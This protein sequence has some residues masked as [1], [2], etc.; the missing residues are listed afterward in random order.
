MNV[1]LVMHWAV[2]GNDL[3]ISYGGEK[4]GLLQ[5][6]AR[7]LLSFVMFSFLEAYMKI[8]ASLLTTV[9]T[10]VGMY[11]FWII[12]R[13]FLG[14]PITAYV[15]RDALSG[16]CITLLLLAFVGKK[17]VGLYLTLWG[18]P[19]LLYGFVG[20]TY[21]MPDKNALVALF[22]TDFHETSEYLKLI[23]PTVY[24][25]YGAV[26]I[27]IGA[28]FLSMRRADWSFL[29]KRRVW[30]ALLVLLFL[31]SGA[32]MLKSYKRH[33]SIQITDWRIS[34]VVLFKDLKAAFNSITEEDKKR[35]LFDRSTHWRVRPIS[36]SSKGCDVCILV[37][38]ESARRDFMQAY[39]APWKDT[40]WMSQTPGLKFDN[41][42]SASSAT[43]PSLSVELYAPDTKGMA[44]WGDNI[45]SLA[46]LAGYRTEWISNQNKGGAVD[47]PVSQAAS[48]ADKVV[49][50]T[51]SV[52]V[53]KLPD[54]AML[55][56]IA[57]ALDNK[58]KVF[59][60]VHLM[61]SHPMA[62]NRT[63]GEYDD[64]FLSKELSCYIKSLKNT[65]EF[66]RKV[67]KLAQDSANGRSW[68]LMYTSDHALDFTKTSEGWAMK[69]MAERQNSF[70]V[71]LFI[72]GSGYQEK[73]EI[74]ALRSGRY[75]SLL[76]A[77]W[78]GLKAEGKEPA[79]ECDWLSN[80][81]CPDQ[82]KVRAWY[83]PFF[84][85]E[86]LPDYPLSDFLVDEGVQ[87]NQ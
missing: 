58:G 51:E 53:T 67:A 84:P 31:I 26:I 32:S 82:N 54:D 28:L 19:S 86:S 43:A 81:A 72:T 1:G 2:L 17:W 41:F 18:I 65:D 25:A 70:Q 71:P 40:P 75:F 29:K 9:V 10:V 42:V 24:M 76:V 33:G 21:G 14:Y 59:V 63:K 69:H 77:Q 55:P 66:L 47:S 56:D 11:L 44:P 39:G 45:I 57:T 4:S 5:W 46:N 80:E 68:S 85:I 34:E 15:L 23:P 30:I 60:F 61:G 36:G 7:L 6:H 87:V 52:N 73:V 74:E 79:P 8:R 37:M 48:F 38:G 78:M 64:Y 50:K 49:F 22:N 12:V 20:L 27:F 35:S 62:C 16:L 13:K 3:L 83:G